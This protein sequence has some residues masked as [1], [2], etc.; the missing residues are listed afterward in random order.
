MTEFAQEAL[1]HCAALV[2]E[3]DKD[4]YLASL[5]APDGRRPY[6]QALYAFNAELARIRETV[7]EP[8]LGEI[9]LQ[10]W[11]DTLSAIEAKQTVDHP[12]AQAFSVVVQQFGLPLEHFENFIEA[13]RNDLYADQ[14]P[15]TALRGEA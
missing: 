4:R 13:W 3:A 5:F 8:M 11:H 14:F 9:R 15:L 10:W 7:S 2:R 1:A 6:L 12:V